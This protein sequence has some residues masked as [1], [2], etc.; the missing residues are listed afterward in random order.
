MFCH[1]ATSKAVGFPVT[2]KIFSNWFKLELPGKIGRP[3]Y[4]SPSMQ[5]TDHK[6]SPS[7]YFVDPVNI[8]GLLYHLVAT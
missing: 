8:S 1:E 7:V 3:R 6:S 5:P 2:S 4:I